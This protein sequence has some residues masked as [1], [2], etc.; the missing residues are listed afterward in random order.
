MN[1]LSYLLYFFMEVLGICFASRLF[2]RG[3]ILSVAD[4][5]SSGMGVGVVGVVVVGVGT[6]HDG[7][8]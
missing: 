8:T 2:V 5:N 1:A 3:G 4:Y 6:F 7:I